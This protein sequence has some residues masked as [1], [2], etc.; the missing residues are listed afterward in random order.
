LRNKLLGW[1]YIFKKKMNVNGSINKYKVKLIVKWYKQK[2]SLDNF[3]T[4]SRVTRMTSIC[5][6]MDIGQMN[7]KNAFLNGN[8]E[9]E[10]IYQM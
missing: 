1:K 3:D 4:Y 9:E 10:I 6:L 2:N 7:I 8:L 5:I